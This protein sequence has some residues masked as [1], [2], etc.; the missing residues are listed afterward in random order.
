M[1]GEVCVPTVCIGAAAADDDE[2]EAV[3]SESIV[4]T[5]ESQTNVNCVCRGTVGSLRLDFV[6]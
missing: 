5:G 2:E 6:V 4:V 3:V 1:P